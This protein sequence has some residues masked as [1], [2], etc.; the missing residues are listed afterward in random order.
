MTNPG[1]GKLPQITD[2]ATHDLLRQLMDRLSSVEQA[3]G[4]I[5]SVS[6]P[7][8]GS[9]DAN[10]Q[11]LQRLADPTAPQ[12]A[13]NL[14]TLQHYVEARLA[15]AIP[16]ASTTT[17]PTVGTLPPSSYPPGPPLPPA[18]TTLYESFQG[19][20]ITTP[21]YGNLPWWGVALSSLLPVDRQAVYAAKHAA[22]DSHCIL[23][24]SWNYLEPG[25]P[26][27]YVVPGRD[28]SWD[29]PGFRALADEIL[30]NGFTPLVFLAGDGQGSG[31][32]YNDPV[33]WTYGFDWLM[34]NLP[35]II[36]AFQ[37]PTDITSQ[38]VFVPGFDGTVATGWG[39]AVYTYPDQTDNYL[40]AIRAL[41]GPSPRCVGLLFPAGI[42]HWG[43]GAANF[44]STAGQCLDVI[45]QQLPMGPNPS[46]DQVWQ[47]AGRLLG[48][49]YH[50]DP[51][52]PPGD[53]PSPPYYLG[54][55]TPRGPYTVVAF[56]YDTYLFVRGAITP[57]QVAADRA[58][59]AAIGYSLQG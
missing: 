7:L 12:D 42:C 41:V 54:I 35:A 15:Q 39:D 33:G 31:P 5:G 13:V 10:H 38:C 8:Q 21:T 59:F 52:Q 19:L 27:G 56:E 53:D 26:Y 24:I 58:Y 9:F 20:T 16:P 32:G 50:R 57:A 6:K 25:Q 30:A 2:R 14:R 23:D 44:S 34:A 4:L 3:A 29:L 1:Y 46:G 22:G 11:L 49:A 45:L 17:T 40:L 37:S 18:S 48:P 55:G 43:A 51:A 28:M 36:G 47:I